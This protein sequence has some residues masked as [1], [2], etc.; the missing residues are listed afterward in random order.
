[1]NKQKIIIDLKPIDKQYYTEVYVD[2]ELV[3]DK[4]IEPTKV[5]SL[6]EQFCGDNLNDIRK[7]TKLF[8]AE[9]ISIEEN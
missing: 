9:R 6:M 2:N 1:M 4:L 8:K 7:A 3:V 5:K